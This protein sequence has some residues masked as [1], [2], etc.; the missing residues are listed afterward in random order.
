MVISEPK[1]DT[2]AEQH[3]AGIRSTVPMRQLDSSGIIPQSIDE[4][5]GWLN[6]KGIVP[7]G[8]PFIRYYIIDMDNNL[9]I[10]IGW[11]VETP[12]FGSGR[13]NAGTLPAG[14]YASLIY[15]DAREGYEGNGALIDWARDNDHS[16]DSWE[17]DKGEAF[18]S[19]Y[20]ILLTGPDDDPDIA[21]WQTEVAIKLAE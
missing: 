11:P 10:E 3:Y 16:W 4:V 21:N 15:A 14:R 5:M 2:R 19:R 18:R 12:V 1:I 6:D 13:V 8:A 20:E 7:T 9:D 17:T